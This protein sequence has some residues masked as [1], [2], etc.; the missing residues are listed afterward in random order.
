[1][2]DRVIFEFKD[3]PNRT[4]QDNGLTIKLKLTAVN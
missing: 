4:S 3:Q 1:M 2:I